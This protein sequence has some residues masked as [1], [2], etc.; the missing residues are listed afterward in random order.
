MQKKVTKG[1]GSFYDIELTLTA[2]D[3]A[4]GKEK[5][6][7][8]FQKDLTLPGFRKGFVPMHLVEEH[9]QPEYISLSIYEHLINKGL[10]EVV[11]ENA[12][13][14]FVGEP[15]DM[16][17]DKRWEDTIV[18]LKLDIFPE[19]EIKDNKWTSLSMK[20]ISPKA[21]KEEVDEALVRLKKNYAD[22]KDTD[23]M[24]RHSISKVSMSFLDKEGQEVDKWT[25]YVG[26]Q[27][28]DEFP[29]FV[30]TF[31][32][33]KKWEE[34]SME[35]KKDLPP[36]LQTKKPESKPTKIVFNLID[37]KDVV[38]P[39]INE[40]TLARLFGK[41]SEVKNE[42]DLLKYIDESISAQKFDTEL[43]KEVEDFLKA[44]RE[45]YMEVLIPQTLLNQEVRVRL[46]NL[47]KR[48]GGKEKMEA[49]FKQMGEEKAKTF[50]DDISLAAKESL[51]KFFILQKVADE[52][53]LDINWEKPVDLEIERKLYEKLVG[54]TG[55][56][57][58]EKKAK[59]VAKK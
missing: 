46:E 40:E 14:K 39:E 23:V 57:E 49:Y 36:T 21:T 33:K 18:S 59:K 54:N 55:K 17:Q 1:K 11:S 27:E 35:Y 45:K 52:L 31:V 43:I 41:E 19:V 15:Y 7:K 28:F 56:E 9:I 20:S 16:K 29:I 25:L 58:G 32:G 8:E 3:H 4:K 30:E 42:S 48:F 51:E 5:A 44:I 10:Q 2:D 22:Y 26:E 38:L 37:I 6:L 50:V 47:E 13:I 24:A 34:F 12:T 53:K